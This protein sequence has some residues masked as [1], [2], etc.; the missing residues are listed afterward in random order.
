MSIPTNEVPVARLKAELL[1]LGE[2]NTGSRSELVQ[3]LQQ[4]GVYSI[5]T[6]IPPRAA[7]VDT[8]IRAPNHSSVFIGNGAGLYEIDD[9]VLHIGNNAHTSLIHGNF[10]YK[11]VNINNILNIESSDFESDEQGNEGDIRRIGPDLYM[12]RCTHVIPGWYEISFGS[13][14]II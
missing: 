11:I 10:K 13:I 8:S 1:V 5:N 3:R 7:M 12:Y 9:N 14:K 2:D 4:C 6:S